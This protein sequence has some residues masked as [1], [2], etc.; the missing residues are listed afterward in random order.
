MKRANPIVNFVKLMSRPPATRRIDH[1]TLLLPAERH[2]TIFSQ[3]AARVLRT[4]TDK[5]ARTGSSTQMPDWI[6]RGCCTGRTACVQPVTP[7]DSAARIFARCQAMKRL[8][9]CG[10]NA[11]AGLVKPRVCLC[12]FT[13]RMPTSLSMKAAQHMSQLRILSLHCPA[14]SG[15]WNASPIRSSRRRWSETVFRSIPPTRCSWR[16]AT[17]RSSRSTPPAMR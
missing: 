12:D 13:G 4:S 11:S 17:A 7:G 2:C 14:R 9:I 16:P 1:R 15:R 10:K 5:S 8:S 6:A 3:N